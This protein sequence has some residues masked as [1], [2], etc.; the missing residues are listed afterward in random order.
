MKATRTVV[1]AWPAIGVL[2]LSACAVGQ[3]APPPPRE[4]GE[5]EYEERGVV[6]AVSDTTI[7]LRTGR[8]PAVRM[9]TPH[10]PL[11]PIAVSVPVSM[12]GESRWDVPAEE[13]TVRLATG[14]YLLV[15]QP[16]A[17]PAFAPGEPVKVQHERPHHITGE[18][19]MRV[20]RD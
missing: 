7:D 5:V 15:V 2:L 19:R 14:K 11:G 1:A 16:Q 4:F 3:S 13:I 20:V 6:A 18:S 10:I 9:N 17:H 8:G 12:G